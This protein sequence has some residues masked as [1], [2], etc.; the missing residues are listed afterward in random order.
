MIRHLKDTDSIIMKYLCSLLLL[1]CLG[2]VNA[3][4]EERTANDNAP[5]ISDGYHRSKAQ[6]A[7]A[8]ST[9]IGLIVL[10]TAAFIGVLIE[11]D[12]TG[13]KQG[14]LSGATAFAA[15][16]ALKYAVKE[17]RPDG[18]NL[19]SFPSGHTTTAF[20][21]A[22]FLQRRYGWKVGVPA[23][24]LSTYIGW[25]RIYAKKHYWWDVLAGAAL[26]AGASLIYT[27]PFAKKHELEL[28]PSASPAGLAI[29]ASL[30]F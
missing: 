4:G 24:V 7:V 6:K 20:A 29:S 22:T 2:N 16:Y 3:L 5:V 28:S 30:V 1:F 15:M 17:K 21:T 26:G 9:D 11:H 10:P 8:T 14:L 12:W 25:G 18:S 27:R 23:Y 19:H 13:L